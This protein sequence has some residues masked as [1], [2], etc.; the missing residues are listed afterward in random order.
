MLESRARYSLLFSH[1]ESN[2]EPV[3]R[4]YQYSFEQSRPMCKR[5]HH[6]LWIKT[7]SRYAKKM[8]SWRDATI[9]ES[10]GSQLLFRDT[11]IN[12]KCRQNGAELDHLQHFL[13]DVHNKK[14]TKMTNL[15][16]LVVISGPFMKFFPCNLESR[17]RPANTWKCR[18]Y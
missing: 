10:R 13:I 18:G 5:Y 12:T 17:P 2:T 14:P 9:P 8:C 16:P 1:V 6:T 4:L 3:S 15:V 11:K 7:S